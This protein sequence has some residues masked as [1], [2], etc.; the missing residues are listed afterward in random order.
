MKWP[1]QKLRR[2]KWF[3]R[4]IFILWVFG[5]VLVLLEFAYRYQ[6]IDFYKS[7]LQGLNP[8]FREGEPTL[9]VFGD[10]FT[11]Q[12]NG[13]IDQLRDSL[14]GWNVVN[15]AVPGTCARHASYMAGRRIA[16]FR[17]HTVIYQMYLGN[18]FLEESPP[19]NWSE[20]S[21]LRNAYWKF[22][23]TFRFT[24]FL[25]Y[26]MGQVSADLNADFDETTV[27]K[28]MTEFDSDKYSGRCK[29][30]I[31]AQPD[32]LNNVYHVKEP[33]VQAFENSIQYIQD[34]EK[35]LADSTRFVVMVIPHPASVSEVYQQQF[36]AM[37]ANLRRS[38]KYPV[39]DRLRQEFS[40]VW[41]A[42]EC[43]KY[44]HYYNNDE[45][46]NAQGQAALGNWVVK[47]FQR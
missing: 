9:L 40:E 2:K 35:Q 1:L 23:N 33:L 43:L 39:I 7:E 6:W 44:G 10:S 16:Q 12:Q 28:E 8:D 32:F 36:E 31:K 41:W 19:V 14:P 13:Y 38:D 5:C 30:L 4:S 26:R 37:G 24:A 27:T 34:I 3:R 15:S 11:A 22:S 21:F 46:L 45:H 20:L 18:D 17:P 29:M 25:N 47:N 42:Q